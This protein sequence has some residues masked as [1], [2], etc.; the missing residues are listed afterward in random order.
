MTVE[1]QIQGKINELINNVNKIIPVDWD[2]LYINSEMS[3]TG[4]NVYFFFKLPDND[5]SFYSLLIPDDFKV[6]EKTFEKMDYQNYVL[7]RELWKIFENNHIE[8]WKNA[9]FIYKNNKLGIHFDYVDWNASQFGPTDRMKYFRYKYME[10]APEDNTQ[11]QLFHEM[12][13]YQIEFS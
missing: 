13:K 1:K 10:V 2:E 12:E 9:C 5:K 11:E 6:E 8:V 7:A 4:G 3:E